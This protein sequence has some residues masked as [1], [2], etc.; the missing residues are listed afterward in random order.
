MHLSQE[1]IV[2]KKL[3]LNNKI[4]LGA[5]NSYIINQNK[6]LAIVLKYANG[7]ADRKRQTLLYNLLEWMK[8]KV[9]KHIGLIFT[10]TDFNI[11]THF[12]KRIKSRMTTKF[13]VIHRPTPAKV[14]E[15]LQ[16]RL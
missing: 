2:N 6:R 1:D 16:R 13:V 3:V 9:M 14:I 4:D 12:E 10:T 5:I 8:G 11:F 7:L 15:I